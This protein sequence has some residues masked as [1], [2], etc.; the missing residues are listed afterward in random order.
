MILNRMVLPKTTLLAIA[1]FTQGYIFAQTVKDG[2]PPNQSQATGQE[3]VA[4]AA[5]DSKSLA[6]IAVKL[7]E[8]LDSD[9]LSV[10]DAAEAKLLSIGPEV[11]EY[12][13]AVNSNS[14]DE[15]RMRID[16]LRSSLEQLEIQR[17]TKPAL[18]TL[19]GTMTGR[20]ALTKIAVQ[21]GNAIGLSEVPNLDRSVVTDFDETPYWEALDEVLDQL[22]LTV[23]SVDEESMRL[24]PRASHAPLRSATA[25]YSGVIRVEPLIV[26]KILQLHDPGK[27]TAQIQTLLAWEPRLAP[28]FVRF[29]MESMKLTCDDGQVLEPKQ[30]NSETEFVPAGGSQLQ[31][32]LDFSLPSRE[33]KKIFRWSGDVFVSIPGKMA[34]LEFTDLMNAN[35]Q[36]ATVGNL[37]VVLEK[38]RKN[39]DIYEVLVGVTLKGDGNSAESFRGWSNTN[40]AYLLNAANERI[41]HVGWST[42]RMT[43]NE[44]GLSYLFDVE[45]GLDGCKFLYRAPATLVEQTVHFILEDVPLP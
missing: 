19:L 33:A 4:P 24:M 6:A 10:R 45:K 11:I 28:V 41:E 22:E 27:S 40:E 2:P 30:M 29:P 31:V 23:A 5:E 36:K 44:I 38:A 25:G 34:K 21:T 12:L 8:E 37:T 9:R 26:Q 1:V 3:Q 15:W 13:P 35:K 14:S 43:D 16:R 32:N 17:L 39:R 42:T 20:D 7:S 18:V